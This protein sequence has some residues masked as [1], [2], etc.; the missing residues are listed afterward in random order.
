L[1]VR[2]V[3][4]SFSKYDIPKLAFTLRQA[5]RLETGTGS[6]CE[7]ALSYTVFARKSKT[8]E[9]ISGCPPS[10]DL[11]IAA[12]IAFSRNDVLGISPLASTSSA[13]GRMN[14][15][16]MLSRCTCVAVGVTK[17]TK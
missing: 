3:M 15:L 2:S 9:A 11:E 4:L 8:D 14:H 6:K 16:N 5:Q 12:L 10:N 7:V 1:D 13:A 17:R